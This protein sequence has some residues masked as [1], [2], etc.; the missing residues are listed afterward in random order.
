MD[1]KVL[2]NHSKTR[3]LSLYPVIERVLKMYA[4][5]KS[6]FLSLEKPPV[7][8]K[9]FFEDPLSEA[10]LFFVH[11]LAAVF[12][13]NTAKMEAEKGSILETMN[14]VASIRRVC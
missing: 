12:H 1:L 13:C 8:L 7:I 5:L 14:I 2:L 6:Y 11:S 3:W 10:L 4:P 9:K